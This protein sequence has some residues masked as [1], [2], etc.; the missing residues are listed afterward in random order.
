MYRCLRAP[1]IIYENF[2]HSFFLCFSFL[3]LGNSHEDIRWLNLL[4][5]HK[6]FWG[7]QS[8]VDS[9][10]FFLHPN[11]KK[12]PQLELEETI[13]QFKQNINRLC[14]FPAR[15]LILYEMGLSPSP[16]FQPCE[17]YNQLKQKINLAAVS[18]VFSSYF[19]QK[20]ASAFGHTFF[21]LRSLDSNH[22]NNELLD[23]GVDFSATVTTSN[24]IIYGIM[25]ILGGFDG[26]F[27]LMPY[28]YKIREYNDM[29]SR[30]LWNYEISFNTRDLELFVAHLLEME[31]AT[32]DYYYLGEN[33]SYHIL[34]FINAIRPD[35]QLMNSLGMFVPPIETIYA[36]YKNHNVVKNVT[37]RPSISVKVEKRFKLLSQ[38]EKKIFLNI[39]RDENL[40]L[41]NEITN[42]QVKANIIEMVADYYDFKNAKILLG[43]KDDAYAL[44]MKQKNKINLIRSKIDEKPLEISHQEELNNAPHQG[45]KTRRFKLGYLSENKSHGGELEYK[46]SLHEYLDRQTGWIPF[47]KTEMG[48]INLRYLEKTNLRLDE[49]SLVG[50][51]AL[52]PVNALSW[53]MSWRFKTGIKDQRFIDRQDYSPYFDLSLGAS[54]IWKNLVTAFFIRSEQAVIFH[55]QKNYRFGL[56]PELLLI[57]NNDLLAFSLE[58]CRLKMI[59]QLDR[60]YSSIALKTHLNITRNFGI[61]LKDEKIGTQKSAY[62]FGV[63]QHF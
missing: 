40:A 59:K 35:W 33:C 48:R 41:L 54:F 50:V 12:N 10:E 49:F 17:K 21:K 37:Y 36:L 15:A 29:E 62:S 23:Y 28:Y 14:E 6:H 31:K 39:T 47:S 51:D 58:L 8:E 2:S 11:G 27:K 1:I 3:S 26:R 16:N 44:A 46:F 55:Y 22:E 4:R 34:G 60:Y 7:Y 5:Y 52:K 24:P 53:P 61:Y 30:D 45:H 20:P 9:T 32:F 56:G 42:S 38:E 13:K 63:L 25:G 57:F 18:L 43:E 19:I